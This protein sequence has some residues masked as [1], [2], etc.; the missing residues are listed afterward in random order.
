MVRKFEEMDVDRSGKL[1]LDEAWAGMK[2]MKMPNGQP[3]EDRDI[4]LLLKPSVGDDGSIDLGHFAALLF[5]LRLYHP[6]PKR[7]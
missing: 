4:E 6:P 7:T 5:R 1:S 3:L 2:T